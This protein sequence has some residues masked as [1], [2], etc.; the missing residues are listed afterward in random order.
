MQ[1]ASSAVST[2]SSNINEISTAVLQA[3]G[4][5]AKTKQAAQVLVR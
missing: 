1:S 2:V 5:V 4:A 3:A